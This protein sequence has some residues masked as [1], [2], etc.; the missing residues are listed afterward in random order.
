MRQYISRSYKQINQRRNRRSPDSRPHKTQ[1]LTGRVDVRERVCHPQPQVCSHNCI[2]SVCRQFRHIAQDDRRGEKRQVL[3]G[4]FVR[5]FGAL[6]GCK[7][8]GRHALFHRSVI[9]CRLG[10]GVIPTTVVGFLD[11]LY[12]KGVGD[13]GEEPVGWDSVDGVICCRHFERS[14]RE[15]ELAV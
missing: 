2:Q 15:E 12:T 9:C 11:S 13:E 8:L 1:S 7:D 14:I 5:G 6:V 4:I 3:H 10:I